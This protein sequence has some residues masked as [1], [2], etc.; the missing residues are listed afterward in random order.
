MTRYTHM[1]MQNVSYISEGRPVDLWIHPVYLWKWWSTMG[2]DIKRQ[3]Y[4]L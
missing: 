1:Y 2:H 4:I 3:K